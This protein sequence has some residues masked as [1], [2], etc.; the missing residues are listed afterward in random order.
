MSEGLGIFH[1]LSEAVD[2]PL[3]VLALSPAGVRLNGQSCQVLAVFI[4]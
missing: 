3:L 2:E 1:N 4:R